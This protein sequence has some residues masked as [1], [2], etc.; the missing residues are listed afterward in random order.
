V[1]A[2]FPGADIEPQIRTYTGDSPTTFVISMN[3]KRRH[4]T[5]DQ[6]VGLGL[7]ILPLLAAEAA[8][9]VGGRPR[10]DEEKPTPKSE[11]VSGKSAKQAAQQ[12]GVGKTA[13]EEMAAEAKENDGKRLGRPRPAWPEPW[14]KREG[15]KEFPLR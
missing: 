3:L 7:K 12:V 6:R 8:K 9:R 13:V 15:E 14:K 2:F 5:Y 11:E 4:L 10:K 1:F